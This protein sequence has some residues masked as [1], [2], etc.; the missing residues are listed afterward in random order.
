MTGASSCTSTSRSITT[1][2]VS[3]RGTGGG[4]SGWG[5][6]FGLQTRTPLITFVVQFGSREAVDGVFDPSG[7]FGGPCARAHEEKTT[8]MRVNPMRIV[9]LWLVLIGTAMTLDEWTLAGRSRSPASE[10][11]SADPR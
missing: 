6:D 8:A 5:S 7:E 10:P 2:R 1:V 4:G 11:P 9:Q 3:M